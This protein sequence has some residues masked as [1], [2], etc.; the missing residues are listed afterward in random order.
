MVC[1]KVRKRGGI[2][3]KPQQRP[4]T[5]GAQYG[6]AVIDRVDFI[7]ARLRPSLALGRRSEQT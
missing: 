4:G 2:N 5:L 1:S 7:R 3:L 6:Q